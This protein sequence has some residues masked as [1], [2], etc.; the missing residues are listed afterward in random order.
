MPKHFTLHG[1]RLLC[2]GTTLSAFAAIEKNKGQ[3][4]FTNGALPRLGAK[5]LETHDNFFE[6]NPCGH[7]AY[8]TP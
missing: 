3:G 8:A 7:S 1:Q 4:H 2:R 5:P 6:L